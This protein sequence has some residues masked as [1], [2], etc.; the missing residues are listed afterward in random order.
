MRTAGENIKIRHK[1]LTINYDDYGPVYAPAVIFIHA[2]PFN[3]N[4][5]E[6]Q[7]EA[8]KSNYRVISYDIRGYGD[9]SAVRNDFSLDVLTHDLI[10]LINALQLKKVAV[11]GLS[12]GGYIALNAVEKYPERFNALILSDTHCL[13]DSRETK[14]DKIRIINCIRKEGLKTFA[15]KSMKYFFASAFLNKNRSAVKAAKKMI[16][17][18]SVTSIC[19][20]LLTLKQ[21]K[22]ARHKLS[23]IRI[24][25][26]IM[27]GK[28]DI[29]TPPHVARD[30]HE[31]TEGSGLHIIG[32]AGHLSNLEN[33]NE[34]NF[35]LKK[36]M[37][38]VSLKR[39]LSEPVLEYKS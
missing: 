16:L 34:F 17:S 10:V 6:M 15:D 20:T 9:S 3:K 5:W 13:S 14:R 2:I 8:L 36:F 31:K 4:M 12:M 18:A 35:Y 30:M 39:R 27:A 11:C 38:K 21:K 24:P 37:D 1:H 25:V 28:E 32:H 7:I 22:E 33:P 29:L 26:L 23:E 19:Q